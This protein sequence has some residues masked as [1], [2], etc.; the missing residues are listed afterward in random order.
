[1]VIEY[2]KDLTLKDIKFEQTE[3]LSDIYVRYRL[4]GICI[5]EMKLGI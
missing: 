2:P 3:S 4:Q 5:I 1:M